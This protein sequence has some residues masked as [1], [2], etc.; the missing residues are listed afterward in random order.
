VIVYTITRNVYRGQTPCTAKLERT[1][2]NSERANYVVVMK[3]RCEPA[4]LR[5]KSQMNRA[6]LGGVFGGAGL[7]V[8]FWHGACDALSHWRKSRY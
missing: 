6:G 2:P 4:Q 7:L 5:L 3:E 8:E 1:E